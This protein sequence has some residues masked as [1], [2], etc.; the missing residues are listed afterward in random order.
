MPGRKLFTNNSD[1]TMAVTLLVRKGENPRDEAGRQELALSP[2]ESRWED[3]GDSHNVYLNGLLVAAIAGGRKFCQEFLVT[4]RGSWI[5]EQLNTCN[6]V[7]LSV[8]DGE[9]ILLTEEV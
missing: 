5:D 9:I 1:F 6:A 2:G 8:Q 7:L 3:Y 4:W